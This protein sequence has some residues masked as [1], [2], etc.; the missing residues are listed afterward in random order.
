MWGT[1]NRQRSLDGWAVGGASNMWD[2]ATGYNSPGPNRE[3]SARGIN[4]DN[5]QAPGSDHPGGANFGFVDGSVR[6]ISEDVGM[7]LFERLCTAQEGTPVGDDP[8]L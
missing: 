7:L 2:G 5:F 6:F 1:E 4:G 8:A 3:D